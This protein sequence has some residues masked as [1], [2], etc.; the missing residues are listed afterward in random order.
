ME[1]LIN[2]EIETKSFSKEVY[3]KIAMKY[4]KTACTVER[5]IRSLIDKCWCCE[6]MEKLNVYYADGEKPTCR[7]FVYLVKNYICNKI[8]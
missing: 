5:N 1:F 6:L 2:Q 7:A 4:G 8:T 3:P